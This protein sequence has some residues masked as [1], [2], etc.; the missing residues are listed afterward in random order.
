VQSVILF[1]HGSLLCGAGEQ[2]EAH[3]GRLRETAEYSR[4]EIGYL[5]YSSPS[6]AEAAQKCA[7][8]GATRVL[9]APY[10]LIPG[11]FV[12]VGL[13]KVLAP[14]RERFPEIE[15]QIAPALG[16]HPLLS[17]AL[18]KCARRAA[19]SENWRAIL[20]SAPQFCE[21]N[22]ECPLY[23]KCKSE[24]FEIRA[25][26]TQTENSS[27]IV[28]HSSLL[29]LVHGSPK[30]E[31]NAD[32]FRVVERVKAT[33]E[34]SGVEVGFMEC[35]TPSIP[36]AIG[37]LVTQGAKSIVAV[38]YFLHAGT[39]VADDLPSLLEA[40]QQEYS[41]VEFYLGDYLGREPL[42]TEVLRRRLGEL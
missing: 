7:D 16:D 17:E 20:H 14:E 2:L 35:N 19:S 8:A 32:M 13:P 40:A 15:F 22:S 34:Y 10:F 33:Q 5:N 12:K 28:Q 24:N 30:P 31:S 9:I 1:S 18:L 21:Q 37:S 36:D 26:R 41:D 11:Y 42:I 39:H 29:V 6:F 38:P 23:E 4:V 3:A 25:T 27:F